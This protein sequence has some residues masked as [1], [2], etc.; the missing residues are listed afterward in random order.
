MP[1]AATIVAA[2]AIPEPWKPVHHV[3]V[4]P[5]GTGQTGGIRSLSLMV[6]LSAG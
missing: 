6:Y 4:S 3:L 1:D 5:R 2:M